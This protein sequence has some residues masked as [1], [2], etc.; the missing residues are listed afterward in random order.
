ML[1]D[2][3]MFYDQP[4]D[5]LIKQYD[6]IRKVVIGQGYDYTIGCSLDYTYFKDNYKLITV[7]LSKQKALDP[8]ANQQIVFQGIDEV[9]LRLYTALEK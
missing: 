3:R 9:K 8:R 4:V 1:T 2:G 6:E 7:D 5:D